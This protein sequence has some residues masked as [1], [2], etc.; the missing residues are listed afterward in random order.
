[1]NRNWQNTNSASSGREHY[2]NKNNSKSLLGLKSKGMIISSLFVTSIYFNALFI[3]VYKK[4]NS[5]FSDC[6]RMQLTSTIHLIFLVTVSS[7]AYKILAYSESSQTS[8]MKPFAKTVKG[9]QPLTIFAKKLYFCLPFHYFSFVHLHHHQCN[10]DH[11]SND[12]NYLDGIYLYK[13]NNGNSTTMCEIC[14]LS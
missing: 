9:F 2:Y 3:L 14:S 4:L 1:M 13:G 5:G 11:V 12:I 10:K 8:K 7:N 6:S